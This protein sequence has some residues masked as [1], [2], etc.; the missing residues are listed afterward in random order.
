MIRRR[1]VR[2]LPF[3]LLCGL[4]AGAATY[5]VAR[6]NVTYS[7]DATIAVSP[8]DAALQLIQGST[9]TTASDPATYVESQ[10]PYLQSEA[11]IKRAQ[12]LIR[13][14]LHHNLGSVSASADQTGVTLTVVGKSKNRKVAAATANDVLRAYELNGN[15]ANQRLIRSAIASLTRQIDSIRLSLQ[16]LDAE[17]TRSA[18]SE[19]R[20]A[21]SRYSQAYSQRQNL[22]AQA[23]VSQAGYASIE[24]ATAASAVPSSTRKLGA[25][26]FVLGVVVAGLLCVLR[27]QLL[28]VIRGSRD[29]AG[30]VPST[31]VSVLPRVNRRLRGSVLEGSIPDSG[32]GEALRRLR[33]SLRLE[34]GDSRAILVASADPGEGRSFVASTLATSWAQAGQQVLLVGGDTRRPE[35][36]TFVGRPEAQPGFTNL[37][38]SARNGSSTDDLRR[39]LIETADATRCQGLAFLSTGTILDAPMNLLETPRLREVIEIA[40]SAWDVVVFDSAPLLKYSDAALLADQVDV[41]VLL[42]AIDRTRKTRLRSA[43]QALNSVGATKVFL[44]INRDSRSSGTFAVPGS[45]VEAN[46]GYETTTHQLRDPV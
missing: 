9:A 23:G 42:A 36:G 10:L 1:I 34:G 18:T 33:V 38:Q 14:G 3:V 12:S 32:L 24:T 11:V 4:V 6:K 21:S 46:P 43:L 27:E 35:L 44:V 40:R 15:A 7:A 5:V 30:L 8:N 26:G 45:G 31:P 2:Y 41:V 13:A 19:A 28:G 17:D 39:E 16:S 22:I 37:L 29:L 25:L 20:A